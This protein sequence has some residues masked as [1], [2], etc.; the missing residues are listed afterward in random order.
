MFYREIARIIGI[1]LFG[2]AVTLLLPTAI[3]IYYEFFAN[4]ADHPQ[5]YTTIYFI[6]TIA[7]SLGL[8]AL[9]LLF[10]SQT[11]GRF[12]RKEAVASVVLVWFF[13]PIVAALPFILSGTLSDPLQA[14]FEV[15]SGFSTTGATVM[16]GK[17][18]DARGKE[19]PIEYVVPG[20]RNTQ[21]HYYGT[22]TPI[23]D[24]QTGKILYEGIEAVSKAL[25]FW[26][27][28]VQWLGGMGIVVLFIAIL[29][30]LGMGGKVLFQSEITGPM[31][32][33]IAPRIKIA[34]LQLWGI[35]LFLTLLQIVFLLFFNSAMSLYDALTIA[36]STISTGGF[37]VHNI[38][39]AYYNNSSTEWIVMLFMV[40][41]SINFSLYYLCF[42]G[43]FY[44][45]YEPEFLLFC[46]VIL[47]VCT[48]S[49]WGIYH[50]EDVS[51]TDKPEGIFSLSAAVRYGFFQVISA[52]TS[53]GFTTT[54]YDI[55]PYNVQTLMLI[56]MFL[57][58]MSGSTAGGIKMIRHYLMFRLTKYKIE[59]IFKPENIS[60]LKVGDKEVD[61]SSALMVLCYFVMVIGVSTFGT[62]FYVC[63]HLD[64]ETSIGLTGCMINNVGFGFRMGGP[65]HS[66][67]FLSPFSL[68]LSCFLMILGRL[69]FYVV[70]AL[71][72]PAF[73][74][75]R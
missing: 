32:E 29:P 50:T 67:A 53:T 19:I 43:K 34:A 17:A 49:A 10:G 8:G 68:I 42:K 57:G 39:I 62:W 60:I 18:F 26:R 55:W 24:L 7:I 52:L 11:Q 61:A 9:C 35:Y 56:C 59:S 36:F 33:A 63:D 20:V 71:L 75:N 37:S 1:F 72:I 14:Y 69:E 70:F 64:L 15:V 58:G 74:K 40:L 16:E 3:D 22:I 54:D 66:C 46:L 31:K 13:L 44:R 5:P 6:E 21:Y 38:N 65:L 2:L 48:F 30:A 28:F 4:L 12:Y 25:L 47:L 51:L 73:W 41:G 45:L 23:R 27:S